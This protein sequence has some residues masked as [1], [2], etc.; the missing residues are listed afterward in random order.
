M[1][2]PA[3]GT[4]INL[5]QVQGSADEAIATD[6]L[7]GGEDVFIEI[8]DI[9]N[10]AGGFRF[11]GFFTNN[12]ATNLALQIS[13][14]NADGS[15]PPSL[16]NL[17]ITFFSDMGR[18][19]DFQTVVITDANGE[20]DAGMIVM[21]GAGLATLF[22]DA[23]ATGSNVFYSITGS[24]RTAFGGLIDNIP[25]LS[26]R[27]AEVPIPAALPLMISGIAGLAFAS[28]RRKNVAT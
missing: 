19:A 7:G 5:D 20:F 16:D 15:T 24:A 12:T 18:T 17:T 25:D 4:V 1:V 8:N 6:V 22:L 21:G 28:R 27:I 23:V 3:F 26:I 10:E 13:T 9:Q 2:T 11:D 14:L